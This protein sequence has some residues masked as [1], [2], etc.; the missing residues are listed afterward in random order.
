MTTTPDLPRGRVHSIDALR[1]FDMFWIIGGDMLFRSLFGLSQ[2]PVS[3]FFYRQLE[4]VEW[5]GFHLYDG[6][7]P[8]FLFIVGL[9]LPF[10]LTKRIERG[11]SRAD[12]FKHIAIRTAIIYFIGLVYY[13]FF[14]LNFGQ[15]R[16]G[17][18]L[19]RIALSYFFASMIVMNTK[20]RG[21]I[22]ISGGILLAWWAIIM[23]IPTPGCGAGSFAPDCNIGE[24]FDNNI[25]PGKLH[26]YGLFTGD[27]TSVFSTPTATVSAMI[28]VFA[29]HWIRSGADDHK[30]VRG[31]VAAG[32][33]CM[34]V[35]RIWGLA[36]P[37]NK[38]LWTST[39]VLLAGGWSLLLFALF[40]WVID[41]KGH[42]KWAF[43]FIVIGMN[44][45]TIYVASRFIDFRDLAGIFIHG[46]A[47][48]TGAFEPVIW[49]ASILAIKWLFLYFL[50]QHRIFVK[51]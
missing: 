15:L 23:L 30:K 35:S 20:L 33:A 26:T 45:L 7:F 2:N 32:I 8:L 28:G 10:S 19:Q 17:G 4:H 22:I 34:V 16:Y 14:D 36:F 18:V 12:L 31:L 9:S 3:Q 37:I 11:E 5:G 6:I 41:V 49:A 21:Q 13:G 51:A 29:G 50:Y 46:F 24:W 27:S 38:F 39:Y 47:G 1:G 40:Y 25:I 43:P 42:V 44:A 48:H